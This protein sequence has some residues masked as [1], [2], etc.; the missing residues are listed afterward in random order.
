[1]NPR[2]EAPLYFKSAPPPHPFLL[3]TNQDNIID[4]QKILSASR[5]INNDRNNEPAQRSTPLF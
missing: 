4:A 3:K 2:S 5:F 1:M